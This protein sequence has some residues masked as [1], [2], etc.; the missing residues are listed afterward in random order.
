MNKLFE[1]VHLSAA[2]MKGSFNA[3]VIKCISKVVV[4]Q[5]DGLWMGGGGGGGCW[6]RC[7][8]HLQPCRPSTPC[9]LFFDIFTRTTSDCHHLVNAKLFPPAA[10]I[11]L[12]KACRFTTAYVHVST[13]NTKYM[14]HYVVLMH[15]CMYICSLNEL[16]W[17]IT[18]TVTFADLLKRLSDYGWPRHLSSRWLHRRDNQGGPPREGQGESPRPPTVHA[19]QTKYFHPPTREL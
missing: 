3:N 8:L 12:V 14:P 1:S 19:V 4:V 5:A 9:G 18:I 15:V 13:I 16:S 6:G 17:A 7:I 11:C 2:Q 10:V